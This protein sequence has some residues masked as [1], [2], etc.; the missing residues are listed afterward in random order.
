MSYVYYECITDSHSLTK[1]SIS[2]GG[3]VV[4]EPDDE[5]HATHHVTKLPPVLIVHERL[6]EVPHRLTQHPRHAT[7]R[8]RV[9]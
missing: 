4:E 6:V 3:E 7:L 1:I 9:R 8:R 2:T 5:H